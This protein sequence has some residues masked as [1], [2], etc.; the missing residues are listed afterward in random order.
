MQVG[1]PGGRPTVLVC[2]L[3]W[4]AGRLRLLVRDDLRLLLHDLLLH[5]H[6]LGRHRAV[7]LAVT[8]G[9]VGGVPVAV[10]TLSNADRTFGRVQV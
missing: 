6:C 1:R 9:P 7:S 3:V 8:F 5:H 2:E 4:L 10:A